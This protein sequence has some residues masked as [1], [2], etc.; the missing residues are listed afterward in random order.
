[1][2]STLPSPF[3]VPRKSWS[4][5]NRDHGFLWVTLHGLLLSQ[6]YEGSFVSERTPNKSVQCF[7]SAIHSIARSQHG[8]PPF[9]FYTGTVNHR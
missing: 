7:G 1:M 2:R 3:E 4:S 9:T 5:A 8:P 6:L